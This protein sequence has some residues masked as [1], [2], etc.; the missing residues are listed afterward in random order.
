M[1]SRPSPRRFT[2]PQLAAWSREAAASL[3]RDKACDR[4]GEVRS[5]VVVA[6]EDAQVL[7][8]GECRHRAHIALGPLE[9]SR[10]REMAQPL[11]TNRKTGLGSEPADDMVDRRAGQAAPFAGPVEIDKQRTGLGAT[12]LEPGGKGSL[13]RFGQGHRLLP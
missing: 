8:A 2:S 6:A 9:R 13:G 10:D 12:R 7:V 4:A 5:I 11:R 1:L 3:C